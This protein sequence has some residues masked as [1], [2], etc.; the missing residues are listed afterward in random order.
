M[1]T[2]EPV[3]EYDARAS[4]LVDAATTRAVEILRGSRSHEFAPVLPAD[5]ARK[6]PELIMA[7][8]EFSSVVF[9][10]KFHDAFATAGFTALR[11]TQSTA[12]IADDAVPPPLQFS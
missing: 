10:L 12:A 11:V 8:S 2:Q 3:L 5:A 1:S 6:T 4:V 7:R 9:A